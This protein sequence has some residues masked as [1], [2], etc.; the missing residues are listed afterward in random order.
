MTASEVTVRKFLKQL[1]VTGHQKLTEALEEAVRAGIAS[2]G[3]DLPVTATIEVG[4][5]KFSHSVSASVMAP[6]ADG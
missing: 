1:G 6:N 4:A 3:S 5:L 2:P